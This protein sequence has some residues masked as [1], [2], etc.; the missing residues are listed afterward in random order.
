MSKIQN[1]RYVPDKGDIVWIDFNPQSGKEITKRRPALVLS[2]IQYNKHG[3]FIVVPITS[4]VKNYPFEVK[5]E[6]EK[7]KGVILAD[8]VKNLDWVA[9]NIEYITKASS[10]SYEEVIKKL[11]IILA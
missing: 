4:K 6:G 10:K 2:P 8:A 5:L 3:L 1:S 11:A 7:I 9:R